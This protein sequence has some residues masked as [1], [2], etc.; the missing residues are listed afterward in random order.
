MPEGG[1]L[2][3]VTSNRNLDQTYARHHPG[4]RPGQYVM[5]GVSDSGT[6]IDADTLAHIFEPFFTT[7]EVGKGTGL[8]LATVY[9]VV[10]Q[11][12]G[13]IWV[14]SEA[15][16]G[17]S[18]QIFLP[19]AD[20]EKSGDLPA[21]TQ[22]G[23]VTRGSE[24]I[25]LVEDSEPLRKLTRSLLDSHGLRVL[26]AQNG[27]DAM[28]VAERHSGKI[29]LLVTDVVMPGINGRVL[30]ERLLARR[31]GLKVLFIS[32]Y[33]DNFI[34]VHGVLEQGMALLNK[35]FTEDELIERVR[36]VLDRANCEV[37]ENSLSVLNE[38]PPRGDR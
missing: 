27:E 4:A 29:H 30:A 10:K 14:D 24:T 38:Q 13:Y 8:G 34:A 9:G 16:K 6:G 20:E 36:E 21:V 22:Q 17:A 15:G 35:P 33:T 1:K 2:S 3:I 7:K 32:G 18:F 5:L 26:V 28:Q 37:V 31:R 11:S 12:D 25:L 23:E 19:K